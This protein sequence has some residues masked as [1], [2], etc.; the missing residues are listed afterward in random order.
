[1]P[2]DPELAAIVGFVNDAGAVDP[3]DVGVAGMRASMEAMASVLFGPPRD[4]VEVSDLELATRGGALAARRYDPRGAGSGTALVWFH[5]GGWTIGSVDTHDGLCREL[6]AASGATVLSVDYRLA[7]EHPFPAA[8]HDAIDATAAIATGAGGPDL[9]PGRVVV[10]G[11]SAGGQLATVACRVLRDLGGPMPAAQVLVYPVTDLSPD[12]GH[13]SRERNGTGYLLTS[14]LIG[15]FADQWV[16]DPALR[17]DPQVS[18]LL[19]GDLSGLPP[20]LVL[21]A[22]HDPLRDEGDAY[23]AALRAAGVPVIHETYTGAVHLFV[24][25]ATTAIGRRAIDQ[26]GSFVAAVS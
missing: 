25:L 13:R 20:A 14:D 16:P 3:G 9:D 26:I 4:D 18:P 24:Q 2:L 15:W 8:V 1:M 17:T 7:P 5:G 12:A 6:A 22:E 19:A 23:A 21:T 10:G 11:D